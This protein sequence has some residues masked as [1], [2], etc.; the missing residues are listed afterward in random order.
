MTA[1]LV[2][3]ALLPQGG[4][5]LIHIKSTGTVLRPS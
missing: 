5:Y 1:A 2:I 3:A 4:H